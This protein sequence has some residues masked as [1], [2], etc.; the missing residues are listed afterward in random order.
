MNKKSLTKKFNVLYHQ[1]DQM[2][3]V[4]HAQYLYFLEQTRIEWLHNQGVS[5]AQLERDGILLPLTKLSIN[6]KSPLH[7]D[8]TFFV[9]LS[10]DFFDRSFVTFS[11]VIEDE[12]EKELTTATTTLVFVDA[13]TR[14]VI[15][16]P[17]NLN[18]I[19]KQ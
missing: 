3:I 9:H 17:L 8:D 16:C 19:F 5:F 14:K 10:L 4:H 6:Y 15:R 18:K 1:V 2:G 12:K 7:F 11:Y 13:S